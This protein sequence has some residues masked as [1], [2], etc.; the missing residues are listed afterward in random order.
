MIYDI[1]IA[2]A[3]YGPNQDLFTSI[4]NSYWGEPIEDM[5]HL[6]TIM[7]FLFG[8]D[9]LAETVNAFVLWKVMNIN[10]IQEFREVLSKYRFFI[11]IKL[12]FANTS[13]FGSYDVKF[14]CVSSGKFEWITPEG[15]LNLIS[16]LTDLR[17]G[18]KA[19]FFATST[20]I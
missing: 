18:E 17:P 19:L 2:C 10:M 11:L 8:I 12:C 15:R 20:Y 14:G 3:Y 9:T 16:N 1:C 5:A 7:L 6:Y 4:A 13:Y